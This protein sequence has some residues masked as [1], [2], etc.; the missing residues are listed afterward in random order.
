MKK[1]ILIIVI[2]IVATSLLWLVVTKQSGSDSKT[3]YFVDYEQSIIGKWIP[4]E[5][6]DFDLEFTKYGIMKWRVGAFEDTF[7]A[8]NL[9]D[10][11]DVFNSLATIFDDM[12]EVEMPYYVD[13]RLLHCK[14]VDTSEEVVAE[15]YIYVDAGVE[16][17]EIYDV[18]NLAGKYKKVKSEK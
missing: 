18:A 10:E 15:I 13:G 12:L 6:A 7:D 1:T 11:Y 2:T 4:V 8:I 3:K 9:K 16:Y 5:E 14:D 17:L